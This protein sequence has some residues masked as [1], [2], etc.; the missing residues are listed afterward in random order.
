MQRVGLK[1]IA[2]TIAALSLAPSFAHA[3]EAYPRLM[4]WP[5]ELWRE[6]TVFNAQFYLFAVVGAPV[7]VLAIVI[8]A[9]LTLV[10]RGQRPQFALALA[11]TACFALG[12]AI[13]FAVVATANS[14]LATWVPG[15]VPADFEAVRRQW[16]FGHLTIAG[17]KLAAFVLLAVACAWPRAPQ[18][19]GVTSVSMRGA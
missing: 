12:L 18:S 14:V 8:A 16:E 3:L 17:V 2:L 5:P 11:G 6:A 9:G 19:G 1:T 7:D 4:I 13:W 10:L 15:P